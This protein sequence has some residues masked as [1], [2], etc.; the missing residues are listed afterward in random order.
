MAFLKKLLGLKRNQARPRI[1]ICLQCGM[2][3]GEHKEWCSI[4]KAQ[5]ASPPAASEAIASNY[6]PADRLGV[7][8]R[9]AE[10]AILPRDPLEGLFAFFAFFPQLGKPAAFTL[11]SSDLIELER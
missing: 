10:V 2:P 7:R 6:E 9:P 5:Q 4:F 11:I 8:D 1:R 3:V